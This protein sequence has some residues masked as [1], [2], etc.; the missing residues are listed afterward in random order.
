VRVL[1]ACNA[2]VT[3]ERTGDASFVIRSDRPGWLS[4]FFARA[5]R[6][7]PVL[8]EGTVYENN[9]FSATLMQLTDDREDVLAVRFDMNKGL[10]DES[11]LFLYWDGKAFR[12]VDLS[13]LPLGEQR[14]LADTSNIVAHLT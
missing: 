13:A 12:P 3:I 5:L 10:S 6:V 9:L 4:N 1:S 7:K 8:R 2:V 14:L 11:I